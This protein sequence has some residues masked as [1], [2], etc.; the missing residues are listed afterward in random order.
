MGNLLIKLEKREMSIRAGRWER[1][2]VPSRAPGAGL[3]S[4]QAP[5]GNQ[6]GQVM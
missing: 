5:L 3:W 1:G 4:Q 2:S 6:R